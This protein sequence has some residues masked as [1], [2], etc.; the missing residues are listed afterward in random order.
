MP[1]SLPTFP[2][3]MKAIPDY[4][5]TQRAWMLLTGVWPPITCSNW[6]LRVAA[7][8][9]RLVFQT[10]LF[11]VMLHVSVVFYVT[12]YLEVQTATFARI[13]YCLSQAVIFSFAAFSTFYFQFRAGACKQ[14]VDYMNENF[15][16]RSAKGVFW[17]RGGCVPVRSK[18]NCW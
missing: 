17:G 3:G 10:F 9:V 14:M 1:Q 7:T 11:L 2:S 8:A 5:R 18:Y 12:F 13:A 15:Q 6:A 16:F 4:F